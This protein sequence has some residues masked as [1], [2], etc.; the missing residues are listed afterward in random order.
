LKSALGTHL[1]CKSKV[2]PGAPAK[3]KE[4]EK[5]TAGF[6]QTF[7]YSNLPII[8]RSKLMELIDAIQNE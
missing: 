4:K 5:A 7:D 3:G 6:F 1:Q 8:K 2:K